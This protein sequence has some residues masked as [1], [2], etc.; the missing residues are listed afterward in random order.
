MWLDRFSAH[1]TPSA[2]PPP[3]GARPYSP[4]PRRSHLTPGPLLPRPGVNQRSASLLSLANTST[5]SLPA[6]ARQANGS[7]LKHE[8]FSS[9]P[10]DVPDPLEVLHNII[11]SHVK[12]SRASE[13]KTR[14]A[15]VV[16]KPE[17]VVEDVDFGGLSLQAFAAE[18]DAG[19]PPLSD[20]HTYTAQSIEECTSPLPTRTMSCAYAP[21][22]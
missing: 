3:Q 1:P 19:A 18:D 20:V 13:G 9:P 2:T 11:G 7:A 16:E 4:A 5:S 14:E 15:E 12:K 8:V 21:C 10:A 6:T 17:E 22:L